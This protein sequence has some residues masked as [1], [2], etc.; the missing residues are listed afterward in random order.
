M[1]SGQGPS[2]DE[3]FAVISGRVVFLG[4]NAPR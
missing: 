3:R 1:I 2:R 4:G